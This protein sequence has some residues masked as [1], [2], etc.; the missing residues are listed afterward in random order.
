MEIPLTFEDFGIERG[1]KNDWSLTHHSIGEDIASVSNKTHELQIFVYRS[2]GE[3]NELY[4]EMNYVKK[5]HYGNDGEYDV[6][7]ITSNTFEPLEDELQEFNEIAE[8]FCYEFLSEQHKHFSKQW[9]IKYDAEKNY[10]ISCLLLFDTTYLKSV[11][12]IQE[13]VEQPTSENTWEIINILYKKGL[14]YYTVEIMQD[15]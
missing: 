5:I 6:E 1:I 4:Y 3:E 10:D 2:S 11:P 15:C 14:D 8:H 7:I 12:E 13:Y 9:F